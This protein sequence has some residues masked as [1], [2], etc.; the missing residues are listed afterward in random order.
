VEMFS[1]KVT[2]SKSLDV[3][4]LLEEATIILE[5]EHHPDIIVGATPDAGAGPAL[6]E[7][8]GTTRKGGFFAALV[9]DF[10]D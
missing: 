7:L 6:E 4:G 5:P 2:A 1:D 3:D 10:N 9:E 8:P